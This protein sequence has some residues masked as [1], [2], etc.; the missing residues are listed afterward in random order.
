MTKMFD[1]LLTKML[2]FDQ[3]VLEFDLKFRDFDQ[4]VPEFD[5]KYQIL[6]IC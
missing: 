3:H 2:D 5:K 4:N 6:I 1:M